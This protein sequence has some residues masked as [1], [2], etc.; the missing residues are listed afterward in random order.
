[1]GSPRNLSMNFTKTISKYKL[2]LEE[3]KKSNSRNKKDNY[4]Q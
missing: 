2:P 1:M 3:Y 4:M